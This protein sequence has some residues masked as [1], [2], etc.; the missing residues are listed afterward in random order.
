MP[1]ATGRSGKQNVSV[2]ERQM[3]VTIVHAPATLAESETAQGGLQGEDL[4]LET[5]GDP[6]SHSRRRIE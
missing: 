2:T 1:A 3:A 6:C 4:A 5:S